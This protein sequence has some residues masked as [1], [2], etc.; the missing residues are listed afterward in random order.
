MHRLLLLP[1][2]LLPLIA[3]FCSPPS[4]QPVSPCRC[5]RYNPCGFSSPG[6]TG[7]AMPREGGGWGEQN[8]SPPSHI[9]SRKFVFIWSDEE[10]ETDG[11]MK[12]SFLPPRVREE[13]RKEEM[14]V[15]PTIKRTKTHKG[16]EILDAPS[17]LEIDSAEIE[18]GR[19]KSSKSSNDEDLWTDSETPSKGTLHSSKG[20]EDLWKGEEIKSSDWSNSASSSLPSHSVDQGMAPVGAAV[21]SAGMGG[22]RGLGSG[23][24]GGLGGGRGGSLFGISSGFGV[25]APG[26]GPIGGGWGFG[27]GK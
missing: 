25:T 6:E 4:S 16:E 17:L 2:Y 3:A 19:I 10:E 8:L 5:H 9:K 7:Y 22:Q 18:Q 20:N 24:L 27:V 11:R 13:E 23:G 12:S 1:I 14:V 26:V 15:P 21:P